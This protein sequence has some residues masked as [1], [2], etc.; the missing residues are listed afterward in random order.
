MNTIRGVCYSVCSTLWISASVCVWGADVFEQHTASE[1]QTA[2]EEL[3]PRDSLTL[4]EA[5]RLK[6]LSATISSPCVVVKTTEGNFA[7]LLLA[8]G[9]R[10]TAQ[11]QVPVLLI[12]RYVTYRADRPHLTSAAGKDVMLFAGF[13]FDLDIGQVVPADLGGDVAFS[14]EQALTVL[15][16][17]RMVALNGSRLKTQESPTRGAWGEQ[18]TAE[19]FVGTWQFDADGRWQGELELKLDAQGHLLGTF[20]SHDSQNRYEVQGHTAGIPHLVRLE[21]TLANTTMHVD[22]YLWTKTR[23]KLGG[24]VQLAGRRFGFLAQK[25][26]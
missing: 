26:P 3:P 11:G 4:Q 2:L 8:W 14:A 20:V 12:E 22:A 7:K 6:L 19:D 23:D 17:A 1:L 21:I 16:P 24:T 18:P 13:Q 9:L 10:R 25:Q 15:P 5:G